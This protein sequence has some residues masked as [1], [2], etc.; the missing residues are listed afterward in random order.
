MSGLRPRQLLPAL[1]PM[2]RPAK[3]TARPTLHARSSSRPRKA[4]RRPTRASARDAARSSA[5]G[6]A[7]RSAR[8]TARRGAGVRQTVQ[9]QVRF[10]RWYRALPCVAMLMLFVVALVF[11]ALPAP[12]AR[13]WVAPVQYA[14]QVQ[15]SAARHGVDPYLACAVIKC[16]SNWNPDATSPV[17]AQG[18]MQLMP[19]TAQEIAHLGLVDAGFYQPEDLYDP[20]TNIEYGCAY[21]AYLSERLDSVDQVIAAYNAG[22][23]RVID[24]QEEADAAGSPFLPQISYPETASY[25]QRVSVAYHEYVRY[26]PAGIT[27]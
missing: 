24:W 4:T 1:Q 11:D 6:T 22:I 3:R 9:P 10:W 20:A 14:Q 5:R 26:Y 19:A 18:L 21:L 23:A 25:V 17:G 12:V 27:H 13:T 15:D 7:K 8:G 2:T 16:E